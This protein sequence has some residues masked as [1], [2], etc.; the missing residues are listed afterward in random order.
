MPRTA[1]S[2]LVAL[3]LAAGPAGAARAETPVTV[4]AAASLVDALHRIDQAWVRD[5]HPA[6]VLS[7]GSS[8]ALAKQ[9]IAGAPADVFLSADTRWMDALDQRH[10]VVPGTETV[11]TANT[12]VLIEPK[13]SVRALS[14]AHGFDPDQVLGKDGRLSVGNT[15]SVP[16]GIYARQALTSL[17]VWDRIQHRLA[18]ATDVRAALLQV[19][20]GAASAGIV[21]GSDAGAEPDVAVAGTFP[22]S[23]HDPIVY[24]GAALTHGNI[25]PSKAYVLFLSTPAAQAIFAA[26]GFVTPAGR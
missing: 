2:F 9:I 13:A 7:L 8:G 1:R 22:A 15:Q 26:D 3:L 23:T 24:P 18:S 16:A 19:A 5:G 20:N 6:P 10:L 4:F 25:A 12:L 14:L 17:G 11:F 21:Y